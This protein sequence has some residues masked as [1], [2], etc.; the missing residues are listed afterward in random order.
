M[1]MSGFNKKITLYFKLNCNY[2]T[3]ER[4]IYIYKKIKH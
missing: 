3:I 4:D 1:S 2:L